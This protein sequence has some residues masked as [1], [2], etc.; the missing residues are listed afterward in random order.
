[1]SEQENQPTKKEKVILMLRESIKF[2]RETNFIYDDMFEKHREVTLI[3]NISKLMKEKTELFNN[4]D[5]NSHL[6]QTIYD[7]A[8]LA[9]SNLLDKKRY[10][11]Y[12]AEL[13]MKF[14]SLE[15]VFKRRLKPLGLHI[16]VET[17]KTITK[18]QITKVE[19]YEE[20]INE[21]DSPFSD[22]EE[23]FNTIDDNA[24]YIE[25]G[26]TGKELSIR[27]RKRNELMV[28]LKSTTFE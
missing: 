25:Q 21:V 27:N 18:K 26:V 12:C 4:M 15:E 5:E 23:I 6:F 3:N 10:N 28:A 14:S 8:K 22:D 20:D 17:N 2:G 24:E 11:F 19:E 13:I 9:H 7:C 16:N 1:M